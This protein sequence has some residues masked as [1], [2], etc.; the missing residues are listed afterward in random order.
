MKLLDLH[1]VVTVDGRGPQAWADAR[2]LD[3]TL[4]ELGG[5]YEMPDRTILVD[6][7][8]GRISIDTPGRRLLP[9]EPLDS[10]PPG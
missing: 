6:D 5:C 2:A 10:E 9:G 1:L 7:R 4:F 3:D 8:R